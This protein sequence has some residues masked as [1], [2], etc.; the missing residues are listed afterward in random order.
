MIA[1]IAAASAR[2]RVRAVRRRLSCQVNR[3]GPGSKYSRNTEMAVRQAEVL[4]LFACI[5][6]DNVKF[7]LTPG[8]EPIRQVVI[9]TASAAKQEA[10]RRSAQVLRSS[11]C[12]P[13]S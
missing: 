6:S 12:R 2:R 9:A 3:S 5:C 8:C 10:I 1:A 4:Q 11:R 7:A 13:L